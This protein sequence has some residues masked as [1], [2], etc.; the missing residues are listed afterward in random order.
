MLTLPGINLEALT[1]PQTVPN[2]R[3]CL[4]WQLEESRQG[5]PKFGIYM[6]ITRDCD[7]IFTR[8]LQLPVRAHQLSVTQRSD[9]RGAGVRSREAFPG[10]GYVLIGPALYSAP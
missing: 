5:P 1:W 8:D 10:K 3:Y 4:I 2:T 6:Y 9:K 7:R